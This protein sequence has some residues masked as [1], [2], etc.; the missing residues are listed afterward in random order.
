MYRDYRYTE[1]GLDNVIVH[2]M[3]VIVDDAG[4]EVYCVPN[5]MLLHKVIAHCIITRSHGIRP[6]ELRFLRTEIGLTQ[7]ELAQI[8]KK[9]HQ[10]IGRWERGEAN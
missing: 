5:I 10:T 2:E 1:C 4:D 9:D 3:N 6:E 7:A 8:V